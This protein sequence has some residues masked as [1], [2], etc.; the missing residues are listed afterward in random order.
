MKRWSVISLVLIVVLCGAVACGGP[1]ARDKRDK[2]KAAP[3]AASEEETAQPAGGGEPETFAEQQ[4]AI[5]YSLSLSDVR[6]TPAP[7]TASVDLTAEPVMA[8]QAPENVTFEYRWYVNDK[9]VEEADGP[10]LSREN[11]RKKQWVFCEA[12]ATSKDRSGPWLHSKFVRVVNMPPQLEASPMEGFSVPGDVTYQVSASDPDNDPLSYELL[13]PLD[14]GIVLDPNTG[15]LTW[16]IDVETVKRLGETI[17]IQFAVKDDEGKK[18]TG[19]V[20]LHLTAQQR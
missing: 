6:L 3:A 13:S 17:E 2:E 7:L 18:T 4:A 16:K 12:R 14:Q 9:P 8:K 15:L 11:Y 1:S 19:S 20:T 10:T 5:E